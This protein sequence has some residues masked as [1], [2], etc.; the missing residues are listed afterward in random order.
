MTRSV[1]IPA[2]CEQCCTDHLD[3]EQS[4][5]FVTGWGFAF[6]D[7]ARQMLILSVNTFSL[8]ANKTLHVYKN[9]QI[10][11]FEPQ[12]C[13]LVFKTKFFILTLKSWQGFIKLTT[14]PTIIMSLK[15]QNLCT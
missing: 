9:V 5:G 1:R 10:W 4:S 13:R 3:T 2:S 15:F 7:R 11:L 6:L 8:Q 12:Q 14:K